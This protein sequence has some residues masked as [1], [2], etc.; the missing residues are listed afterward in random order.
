MMKR[1]G[2][3]MKIEFFLP[4][5]SRD[6]ITHHYFHP[7]TCREQKHTVISFLQP[8]GTKNTSLFPSCNLQV[9]KNTSLFPSCN[10]QG[11]KNELEFTK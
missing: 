6:Q 4:A 5:T 2:K 8:A 10:L 9:Q 3:K 7:A 11:P 1:K